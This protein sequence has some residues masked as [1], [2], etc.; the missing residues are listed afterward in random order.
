M[1]QFYYS[2][3]TFGIMEFLGD[4]YPG[5][6]SNGL[7]YP[8]LGCNTGFFGYDGLVHFMSGICIGFGLLWLNRREVWQFI[9]WALCIAIFWEA[10]EWAYDSVRAGIL[11]MNLLSP[12]NT[13]TQ[14][15]G[16]DTLGDVVLGLLGTMLVYAL[17]RLWARRHAPSRD[18]IEA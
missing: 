12:R 6:I 14:P 7:C 18:T 3:G 9:A 10:M 16:I 8:L 4:V 15:T 17:W 13:M 11:H 1:P 5:L 2:L